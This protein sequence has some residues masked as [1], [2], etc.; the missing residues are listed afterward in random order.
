MAIPQKYRKDMIQWNKMSLPQKNI[1]MGKMGLRD[2]DKNLA[3][4]QIFPSLTTQRF[5]RKKDYGMF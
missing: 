4:S 2:L 1:I 5:H 3:Y